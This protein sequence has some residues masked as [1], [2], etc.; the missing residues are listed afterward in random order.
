MADIPDSPRAQTRWL[1]DHSKSLGALEERLLGVEGK[2]LGMEG[3]SA[4]PSGPAAPAQAVAAATSVAPQPLAAPAPALA[5]KLPDKKIQNKTKKAIGDVQ[6]FMDILLQDQGEH[7]GEHN[8]GGKKEAF[9]AS[10]AKFHTVSFRKDNETDFL[11]Y[12][13]DENT[14]WGSWLVIEG[15]PWIIAC[16][17]G[18]LTALSGAFIER[19]VDVC[20]SL[21]F[22]FMGQCSGP[23]PEGV[24]VEQ[25]NTGYW[26]GDAADPQ[27]WWT[28]YAGY[29][30][31]STALAYLSGFMTRKF[32]PM[33]RGSGIPEIKTILGGFT[34]PQVLDWNTLV[35]KIVGLGLS[36]ASGLACGKEGPLVH[37]ACCWC[38]VICGCTPRYS[39]NE[40]KK[41]ELL[42]CA[43][44]SGVAVAFGAPLGGVLFA[45]EEASTYF[46]TKVM[47][48]AFTGGAVAAWMLELCHTDP[49]TGKGFLTMFN[50]NYPV[51]PALVEYLIFIVIG[52]AGGCIG[53]LF[54]HMNIIISK[55]RAPDS[56]WRAKVPI[57]F[58]VGVISLITAVTSFPVLWTR[59]IS[60]STIKALFH[61]CENVPKD[62]SDPHTVML[63]LCG[64]PMASGEGLMPDVSTALMG[65]LVFS[66]ALRYFQMT[67]TFG[68][69]APSG[70]FIPSLYTGA[71]LGRVLGTLLFI[72]N[73]K[74]DGGC[75]V[76]TI[77]PGVYSMMGA[78][79][80]LGG[81]CRVTISLVVI[82]FELTNG[83]QLIV[84]FM[85]VCILAKY[86]G[87]VFTPGIYD[88]C[89]TVRKYPFLHEPDS[90]MFKTKASDLVDEDLQMLTPNLG[91]LFEFQAWI[92][93]AKFGGYPV[94]TSLDDPVFL[95]YLFTEQ[96]ADYLNQQ[97]KPKN[98]NNMLNES[99]RIVM[100]RYVADIPIGV[101]DLT[102]DPEMNIV[103]ESIVTVSVDTPADMVHKIFR[104]LGNK[105]I[106]VKKEAKLAGLITKKSFIRHME[107]LHSAEENHHRSSGSVD[108]ELAK[109]V[110]LNK[111]NRRASTL[112][113]AF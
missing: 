35:V 49:K 22:N 38:N 55:F 19:V 20:G 109:Q 16:L 97:V 31:V 3:S 23:F 90:V 41:R 104:Q 105:V 93:N 65:W 42:S 81:V 70:L 27:A 64:V 58:E 6:N 82:M 92:N 11:H 44:A 40:G 4:K 21:R 60:N 53:A 36:V 88:Y 69:G 91:S 34:M 8:M 100:G 59:V 110:A 89:M 15:Q 95:G 85:I 7:H 71:A 102:A 87:E 30:I 98:S 26:D 1:E 17:V 79:A 94:V 74:C 76:H 75:F 29:I 61:N 68:C 111:K 9:D 80:V 43:C 52:I 112:V 18:V 84:P 51:G 39:K 50:A 96:C 62:G 10:W 73:G 66:A 86:S 12:H 106:I 46:P 77:Y 103:D 13:T 54:V 45:L 72:V 32:A 47:L 99:T 78:A 56:K 63:D 2:V 28:K 83:L 37:I 14:D 25:C 67:F 107:S 57:A 24:T 5:A 108:P 48:K 113:S 101:F 33:A